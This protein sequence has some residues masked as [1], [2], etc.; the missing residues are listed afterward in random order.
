MFEGSKG[1]V[2]IRNVGEPPDHVIHSF[3]DSVFLTQVF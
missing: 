2:M 1:N 3:Q